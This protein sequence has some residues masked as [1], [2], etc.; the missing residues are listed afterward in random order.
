MSNVYEYS[1]NYIMIV[2]RFVRD[3]LQFP[4]LTPGV[5]VEVGSLD[6]GEEQR[7]EDSGG[8]RASEG[9]REGKGIEKRTLSVLMRKEKTG[10]NKWIGAG[11]T[12]TSFQRSGRSL[13]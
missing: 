7:P 3:N 6:N 2:S 13:M 1:I 8:N 4:L 12:E 9:A 5:M 10:D 11:K